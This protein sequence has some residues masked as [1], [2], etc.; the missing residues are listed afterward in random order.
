MPHVISQLKIRLGSVRFLSRGT[1]QL[2]QH[3]RHAIHE[4][5]HI[6]TFFGILHEGPLVHNMKII[7]IGIRVIKQ[8]DYVVAI[9]LPVKEMH[10]N[11]IL[12]VAVE[13]FVSLLK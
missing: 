1:L 9:F 6:G 10:F 2:E 5:N 3:K 13:D 8:I 12:Q 4:N 7:V 11:T